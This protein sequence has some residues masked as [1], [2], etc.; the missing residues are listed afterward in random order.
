MGGAL[1]LGGRHFLNIY[2]NHMEV[3]IRGG[4]YIGEDVQLGWNV[5]GSQR[6]CFAIQLIEKNIIKKIHRGLRWPPINV[7]DSTTHQKWAG[8]EEKRVEKRDK[9]GGVGEGCQCTTSACGRREGATNHIINDRTLLCH[10]AERHDPNTAMAASKI[11]G[12]P[13]LI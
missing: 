5:R 8:V 11:A 6:H 13:D 7:F 1:A 10:D 9:R 2:N 4:L 3:G 12:K